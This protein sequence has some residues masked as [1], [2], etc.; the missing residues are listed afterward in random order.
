MAQSS[1]S[2]SDREQAATDASAAEDEKPWAKGVTPEQKA[3][4]QDLLA[5]G[6][7]LFV[8]SKH[9]E[10]LTEYRKALESWDHPAIRFNAARA[11]INLD[12]TLEA[13]ENIQLALQYGPAPLSEL[14]EEAK[15]YERL[16]RGQIGEITIRCE[17]A[18]VK[19]TVDGQQRFDCP[20]EK[21]I[22][23]L[24]G[25]HK[26]LAEKSGFLPFSK[27]VSLLAAVP[28]E[29]DIVLVTLEDASVTRRRW[30]RWK[31]WAVVGGGVA[32]TGLGVTLELIA[33]STRDGYGDELTRMCSDTPCEESEV[34]GAFN[35]AQIE[36]VFGVSGIAIGSAAI[37]SGLALV[38][39]NRPRTFLAEDQD[40]S[41][42]SATSVV[43]MVSVDSVGAALT[44]RF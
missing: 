3:T 5:K 24:P 14:H 18:G 34:S 41:G 12:R 7:A 32:L 6:N 9:L 11:L 10:A 30:D 4:A 29:V 44:H 19:V 15:N 2:T 13:Y 17:Q 40:L 16:L 35:R 38:Y 43:P 1:G 25:P 39:L 31:P 23:L 36:H 21:T 42:P 28:N 27:D 37:L 26:V 33:R 22:K 8:E 20:V